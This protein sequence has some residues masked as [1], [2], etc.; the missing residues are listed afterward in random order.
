MP[1]LPEEKRGG[2]VTPDKTDEPKDTKSLP[3]CWRC[4]KPINYAPDHEFC[5][6]VDAPYG[7]EHPHHVS[8]EHM[9]KQ[10][11]ITNHLAPEYAKPPT[12]HLRPH[13][14]DDAVTDGLTDIAA[15]ISEELYHE[16]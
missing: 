9:P 10:K 6:Y 5:V 7:D 4:K 11:P 16:R 1:D 13:F 2:L 12:V 14:N 3:R 15:R 8:K